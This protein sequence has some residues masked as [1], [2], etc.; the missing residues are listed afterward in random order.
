MVE[1]ELKKPQL[2]LDRVQIHA[3]PQRLLLGSEQGRDRPTMGPAII[4]RMR[5]SR[6]TEAALTAYFAARIPFI[7]RLSAVKSSFPL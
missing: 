6:R 2:R 1:L 3:D 4:R 7:S 5:S